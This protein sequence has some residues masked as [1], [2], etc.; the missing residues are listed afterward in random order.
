MLLSGDLSSK[1]LGKIHDIRRLRICRPQMV[2]EKCDPVL[3]KEL[4][5]SQL[6]SPV[7]HPARYRARSAEIL[8]ILV[9]LRGRRVHA[10]RFTSARAEL[11]T[12]APHVSGLADDERSLTKSQS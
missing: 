7:K 10:I 12:G 2:A 3:G 4:H 1:R 6:L 11:S 9:S 8:G 5:E